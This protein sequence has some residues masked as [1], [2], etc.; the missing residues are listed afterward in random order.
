M[1]HVSADVD[2]VVAANISIGAERERGGSVERCHVAR[3]VM[4]GSV[5]GEH[6]WQ[7]PH[8]D[9]VDHT[10]LITSVDEREHTWQISRTD[11]QECTWQ[12]STDA[13][14]VVAANISIRRERGEMLS[15]ATWHNAL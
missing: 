2:A 1:L 4:S 3:R 13:N 7:I 8:V 9:E 14:A 12:A 10:W 11:E 5:S 15:D 6:T